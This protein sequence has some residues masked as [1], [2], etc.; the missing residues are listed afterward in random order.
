MTETDGVGVDYCLNSLSQEKLFASIRSLATAGKFLEI[1]KFDMANDTKLGLGEFLREISFH[2]VL[3]DNL[4]RAS[5]EDK[6]VTKFIDLL[7]ANNHNL[8]KYCF[9]GY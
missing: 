3:V 2:A 8:Q 9:S 6:L 5:L 1:G 4:F 7:L